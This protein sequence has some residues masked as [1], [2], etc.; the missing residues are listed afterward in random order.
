MGKGKVEVQKRRGSGRRKEDRAKSM[1]ERVRTGKAKEALKVK[2]GKEERES[3]REKGRKTVQ[4]PLLNAIMGVGTG[5]ACTGWAY[6]AWECTAWKCTP[7]ST[8][9]GSALCECAWR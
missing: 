4:K 2:V 7:W 5:W 1:G 3:G 6:T 9:H 8:R